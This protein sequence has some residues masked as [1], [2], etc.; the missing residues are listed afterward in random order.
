MAKIGKNNFINYELD[1]LEDKIK[2]M[3]LY[4]DNNPIDSVQDRIEV[5]ESQR[6]NPIIKV[7]ATKEHQIKLL[8]E[9]IREMPAILEDVNLKRKTANEEKI[10]RGVRGQ[11]EVPDF[12]E[13]DGDDDM[14]PEEKEPAVKKS[15]SNKI[16]AYKADKGNK[17]SKKQQPSLPAPPVNY[18]EVEDDEDPF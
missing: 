1:W 2:Q 18:D 7:I 6:G 13:D 11:Q 9:L 5:M 12:M 17:K 4:V 14:P 10:A 8:K 15:V 16:I 3:M